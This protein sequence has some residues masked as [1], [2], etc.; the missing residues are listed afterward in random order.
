MDSV[1]SAAKAVK[2]TAA[3]IASSVKPAS[4]RWKRVFD[5]VNAE[6]PQEH[7]WHEKLGDNFFGVYQRVAASDAI[8]EEVDDMMSQLRDTHASQTLLLSEEVAV[9]G[10]HS[11]EA[12]ALSALEAVLGEDS[13]EQSLPQPDLIEK[14]LKTFHIPT[15]LAPALIQKAQTALHIKDLQKEVTIEGIVASLA[16]HPEL[17]D[18][19]QHNQQ[20][21]VSIQIVPA[22][23]KKKGQPR[24]SLREDLDMFTSPVHPDTS[25]SWSDKFVVSVPEDSALQ[26]EVWKLEPE[27]LSQAVDT[28]ET[29]SQLEKDPSGLITNNHRDQADFETLSGT[30]SGNPTHPSTAHPT[31]SRKKTSRTS[32]IISKGIESVRSGSVFSLFSSSSGSKKVSDQASLVLASS[33]DLKS[34]PSL[35]GR[36][37]LPCSQ[38]NGAH[39]AHVIKLFN[40]GKDA[41]APVTINASLVH[42]SPIDLYTC[43][44]YCTAREKHQS[45]IQRLIFNEVQHFQTEG[46]HSFTPAKPQPKSSEGNWDGELDDLELE[47]IRCHGN[48]TALDP[49]H[50][51]LDLFCIFMELHGHV[52]V[53]PTSLLYA[54]ETL[55]RSL[56]VAKERVL[57]DSDESR[58]LAALQ[59][60]HYWMFPIVSSPLERG[61]QKDFLVCLK[62]LRLIY[63]VEAWQQAMQAEVKG[64]TDGSFDGLPPDIEQAVTDYLDS[65]DQ[66]TFLALRTHLAK[67]F[68]PARIDSLSPAITERIMRRSVYSLAATEL[69]QRIQE[70]IVSS[71]CAQ[72]KSGEVYTRLEREFGPSIVAAS[73]R[74]ISMAIVYEL[75]RRREVAKH[76][77]L[78]SPRLTLHEDLAK[79]IKAYAIKRY[80]LL[81]SAARPQNYAEMKDVS[82]VQLIKT[83]RLLYAD[84]A[85]CAQLRS[86]FETTVPGFDVVAEIGL[87]Y[88]ALLDNDLNKQLELIDS[89]DATSAN[90]V[91]FELYLAIHSFWETFQRFCPKSVSDMKLH[92]FWC[93]FQALVINWILQCEQQ[94]KVMA[95]RAIELDKFKPTGRANTSTSVQDLFGILYQVLSMWTRIDWPDAEAAEQALFRHLTRTLCE[96]VSH[97]SKLLADTVIAHKHV[98]QN[99]KRAVAA[100]EMKTDKRAAAREAFSYQLP[101]AILI[102]INDLRQTKIH[103]AELKESVDLAKVVQSHREQAIAA[104]HGHS[105]NIV[106]H[107]S[108]RH[109]EDAEQT[110]QEQLAR[111][112]DHIASCLIFRI[113][114]DLRVIAQVV[115]E[116]AMDNP[117]EIPKVVK[118][119]LSKGL[120]RYADD[121]ADDDASMHSATEEDKEAPASVP[122]SQMKTQTLV[123]QAAFYDRLVTVN[124]EALEAEGDGFLPQNVKVVYMYSRPEE[125]ALRSIMIRLWRRIMVLLRELLLGNIPTAVMDSQTVLQ[126]YLMAVKGELKIFFE[127]AGVEK[128]CLDD[129]SRQ[130]F[131]TA[132]SF[133]SAP[134]N[135]LISQF[136]EE[137]SRLQSRPI[138]KKLALRQNQELSETEQAYRP[139]VDLGTV[140]VQLVYN[141]ATDEGRLTVMRANQLPADLG[142][143]Y[144]NMRLQPSFDSR[145]FKYRS[146][147]RHKGS[148]PTINETI[149]IPNLSSGKAVQLRLQ[150]KSMFKMDPVIGEVLICVADFKKCQEIV[151]V[152]LPICPLQYKGRPAWLQRCIELRNKHEP[153]NCNA[154]L[155]VTKYQQRQDDVCQSELFCT[156][157]SSV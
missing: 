56:Q 55:V 62:C 76:S 29:R 22:A 59:A 126:K 96:C 85:A 24:T 42:L 5:R 153:S 135:D 106:P 127:M 77:A 47:I 117:D 33:L 140:T 10:E 100:G 93:R 16:Q 131:N 73:K 81:K 13:K 2:G 44:H 8:K 124:R 43:Q 79:A 130:E 72:L 45:I 150:A 95:L 118:D 92:Q 146:R 107:A 129:I 125:E 23:G 152:V 71:Q 116:V 142:S 132:Y 74:S 64:Q 75:N 41:L 53:A 39:R 151:E 63:S 156:S 97:Y 136:Y 48:W 4:S 61:S 109:F 133:L 145:P 58:M 1:V 157:S 83:T 98:T 105:G 113:G 115:S 65:H 99:Y 70:I 90:I 82:V 51:R 103:L 26:V 111:L 89:A 128:A 31:P 66:V 3:S 141:R 50:Q 101:S 139:Q 147:Q 108:E 21:L 38:L 94:G 84:L 78:K 52:R 86:T 25:V 57:S 27:S 138:L 36:G 144:V 102:A 154:S 14:I 60:L 34:A 87:A 148:R 49:F 37:F 137:A 68:D 7:E 114:S 11:D 18:M 15:E 123:C 88:D 104:N 40:S 119:L 155:F 67:Q 91:V 28:E 30:L 110:V 46:E 112:E 143:M 20:L 12:L 9:R 149:D 17:Q 19:Q 6:Q 122:V 134:A 32:Q 120:L 69:S 121:G 35:V 80:H 54:L